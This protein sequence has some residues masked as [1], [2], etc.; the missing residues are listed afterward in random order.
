WSPEKDPE[1]FVRAVGGL[2]RGS[3]LGLIAGDGPL[4]DPVTSLI[5]RSEGRVRSLGWVDDAWPVMCA[6]DIV[7]NTSRWEGLSLSV[8]EAAAS[9]AALVLTDVPG[10]R[11]VV[12]AGV[13]AV[14]VPPGNPEGLAAAIGSLAAE[15]DRRREL[16]RL[17][18][19]VVR[20]TFIPQA[21]AADVL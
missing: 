21:L 12:D 4:R 8:L 5:A 11:D 7:V 17:G 19:A 14:L 6:S 20:S 3:A 15:P 2:P 10:N 1:T 13:P 16:G 9:G 18:A